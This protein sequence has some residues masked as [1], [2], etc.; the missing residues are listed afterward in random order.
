MKN[1][2]FLILLIFCISTQLF[3]ENV[4]LRT[5]IDLVISGKTSTGANTILINSVAPSG[6]AT[7]ET[8]PAALYIPIENLNTDTHLYY[9]NA[10]SGSP[11]SL[12]N[13]S[14][15]TDVV[16]IPLRVITP[17]S[18]MFL[19]AAVKDKADSNKFKIIKQYSG[20]AL[21]QNQTLDIAFPLS[22]FN[23]CA[24][25]VTDCT[26]LAETSNSP[27]EK[28]FIV[29]FFLS[30]VSGYGPTDEVDVSK[31]PLNNGIYFNVFMSNRIYKDETLRITINSSKPG[32]KRIILDYTSTATLSSNYAKA[33]KVFKHNSDPSASNM[34]IGFNGYSGAL[35]AQDFPYAQNGNLTVTGLSNSQEA[36]LSV[37]FLDK[38]N[39]VTTV[40]QEVKQTP[41]EIQELLKK[42]SCFLLTAG[43]GEDHYVIDY[44][45]N[46]RDQILASTYIGRSFIHFYYDVA[47]KYA[48]IIYQHEGI[49]ALI[50]GFAYTL[51]FIF[52]FYYIFV[53]L[54]VG[55]FA[56]SVIQKRSK[57]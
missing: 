52:N 35:L 56:Y 36:I 42:N 28:D 10:S 53:G 46:F 4:R 50:R 20:G 32:D 34:P 40:S 23:I 54:F 29:Y 47:P 2:T 39:F 8:A 16:N 1:I 3:A 17:G 5:D 48:L 19:Y 38:F 24:L 7:A 49:R 9:F 14:V 30:A 12:F 26:Y 51:Y 55:I 31:A 13:T 45:R 27:T 37:V 41:L 11:T 25:L 6:D 22:P 33:V 43:F 18:D 57:V 44:F 15:S 21:A